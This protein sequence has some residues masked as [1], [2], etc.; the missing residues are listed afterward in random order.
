M[1]GGLHKTQQKGALS[2]IGELKTVCK[3]LNMG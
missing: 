1:E 2:E 3:T